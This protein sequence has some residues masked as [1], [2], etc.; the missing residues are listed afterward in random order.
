MSLSVSGHFLQWPHILTGHEQP[1]EQLISDCG[2][3]MCDPGPM[4]TFLDPSA[5]LS[6][7]AAEVSG[8]GVEDCEIKGPQPYVSNAVVAGFRHPGAPGSAPAPGQRLMALGMGTAG[9]GRP[10][11][12]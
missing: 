7:A 4:P 11:M 5:L 8:S 6:G 3:P 1:V 10:P 2:R 9:D 12:M